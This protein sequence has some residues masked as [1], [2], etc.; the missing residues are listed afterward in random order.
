VII[1]SYKIYTNVKDTVLSNENGDC[2]TTYKCNG[3]SQYKQSDWPKM[4]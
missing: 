1:V 2:E 3:F 4:S